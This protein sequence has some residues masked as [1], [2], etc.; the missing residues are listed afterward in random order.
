MAGKEKDAERYLQSPQ[1]PQ[2]PR[3]QAPR[4]RAV[5]G[6]LT[7]SK[8]RAYSS[9]VAFSL[10]PQIISQLRRQIIHSEKSLQT[11]S[12]ITPETQTK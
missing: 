9:R 2:G 12:R 10:Q 8:W 5:N 11:R 1:H 4:S 3:K 6:V 7:G